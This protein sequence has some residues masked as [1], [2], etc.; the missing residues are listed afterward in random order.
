MRVKN[1]SQKLKLKDFAVYEH[2]EYGMKCTYAQ[3]LKWLEEANQFVWALQK[4]QNYPY[5]GKK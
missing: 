2:L 1:N 5:W 4:N 3:S